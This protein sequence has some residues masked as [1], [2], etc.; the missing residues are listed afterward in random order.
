MIRR[1]ALGAVIA[2]ALVAVLPA[3]PAQAVF[4]CQLGTMCVTNFYTDMQ[5][6]N[7]VGGFTYNPCG[8]GPTYSSWGIQNGFIFNTNYPCSLN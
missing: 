3:A 5:R 1:L 6:T 2:S 7:L 8:N 4:P